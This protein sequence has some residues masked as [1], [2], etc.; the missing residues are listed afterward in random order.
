M[1]YERGE[2][3]VSGNG[4]VAPL[5]ATPSIAREDRPDGSVLL[6]C[7]E[8]LT[9]TAESVREWL[10]K[11]AQLT[12]ERTL[13]AERLA[14]GSWR[15]LSYEGAWSTARS[16]GQALLERSLSAERP[17][18]ILSGNSV[19]HFQVMLGALLSGVTFA[20]VSTAYSLQSGDHGRLRD[21]V[22]LLQPG[23]MFVDDPTRFAAAL[24]AVRAVGEAPLVLS[25][26]GGDPEHCLSSLTAT[27]AGRTLDAVEISSGSVAKILFTSGSTGTPKGVVTTHG[28]LCTNQQM[29]RHAWP[30]LAEEPPVLVDWLPWSHTFGGNH[31]T[32]MV[33]ANGGSLYIDDGRPSP[34]AIA[35]SVRNVCDV[36]PTLALNVPAGYAQ[37]L[38][39]L[40]QN[41]GAAEAYFRRLRLLFNAGAALPAT[42][43][44]RL[45]ELGRRVTGR[46][47][48]FTGAWGTTETAPA[49]TAAHYEF[50]DARCIGV[51]LPG[52]TVKLVPSEG[53]T[54]EIRCRGPNVT[55]GYLNRPD[56]TAE[57]FDEEGFYKP[58][59]AVSFADPG[60]P[61]AG[62]LF[63]GRL[64]EDFKLSTGTFVRVGAV[65]T[66]LLSATP[67]L[68]DAVIAGDGRDEVCALG[69]LN[70][71]EA[72][73]L[74]GAQPEVFD[75][76]VLHSASLV[77]HLGRALA[78]HNATKG[79][80]SRVERLLVTSRP[81]SLDDGE[82]TDKGYLNQ[83][84]VLSR[85]KEL[86]ARLYTAAP[87]PRVIVPL[88][89]G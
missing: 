27:V 52:V 39:I 56:L 49:A 76:E 12:P 5:F 75:G 88:A 83:R 7:T 66:A 2:V 59:D 64:A 65:R 4:S 20:P 54:Y 21:M 69:W 34:D 28:M 13:V 89:D 35:R 14:D 70:A 81:P 82:I 46:V 74:W 8:P 17:L 73:R 47:I 41:L 10:S 63:R 11:W 62:L 80:A 30:F 19:A 44:E 16:I 23:A 84:T 32:L 67:L 71:A 87:D 58:G 55:P 3:P 22:T 78:S 51:P 26:D 42:A 1:P 53:D 37:L 36:G 86:V 40:E 43:R 15:E 18:M 38:P 31:D 79:S 33:L 48:P 24:D 61:N 85:R 77:T 6:K 72:S 9:P 50:D 60:N 57:A 29:M 68:S 25:A 45:R